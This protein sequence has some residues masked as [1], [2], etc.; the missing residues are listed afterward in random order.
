VVPGSPLLAGVESFN[1]GESSYRNTVDVAP[2]ATLIANWDDEFTTP[3]LAVSS[4]KAGVV[5]GLNFY[6]PSSDIREDFWDASTDGWTLLA[7]ALGAGVTPPP[8]PSTSSTTSTT[9]APQPT[10][11]TVAA[12]SPALVTPRFTG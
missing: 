6:P 4:A 8:P 11:T 12:A 7:N 10:T 3:F 1:G 5:V 2:T 9:A